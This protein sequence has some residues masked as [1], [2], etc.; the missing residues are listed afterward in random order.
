MNTV[1]FTNQGGKEWAASTGETIGWYAGSELWGRGSTGWYITEVNGEFR[2]IMFDTLR[3]AK[4]FLVRKYNT[5][6]YA[7]L[8]MAKVDKTIA[9]FAKAN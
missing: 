2:G 9:S 3:D 7:E 4:E 8:V 6:Q 1:T 5:Q